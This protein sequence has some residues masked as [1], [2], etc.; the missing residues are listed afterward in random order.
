VPSGQLLIAVETASRE[1]SSD[2][3][4]YA[5]PPGRPQFNTAV[6]L[7]DKPEKG[8]YPRHLEGID[9][10]LVVREPSSC[11]ADPMQC[12]LPISAS[13]VSDE[14]A[15]LIAANYRAIASHL[16]ST[17][18]SSLTD[19]R[20]RATG[21][22]DL[23]KTLSWNHTCP[24]PVS[25]LVHEFIAQNAASSPNSPAVCASDAS[26]TYRELDE[27]A[28]A[29]A[30]FL[31][32]QGIGPVTIVPLCFGKSA[33]ATVAMLAVA[34]AGAAFT[35]LDQSFPIDALRSII[36]WVDAR[37]LFCSSSCRSVWDGIKV[38][39][40][41]T[42]LV[43]HEVSTELIAALSQTYSTGPPQI[44]CQPVQP[45]LCCLHFW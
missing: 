34:K 30:H 42:T 31:V 7:L 29:P 13:Q 6:C 19:L 32:C 28:S 5:R 15:S 14:A 43:V 44:F 25:G 12:T 39:D 41:G 11:S 35:L 21:L 40:D 45:P 24:P 37:F 38:D 1:S 36:R 3:F 27:A 26:L 8:I 20:K 10:V 9:L 22:E 18:D 17:P 23:Q 2:I 16:I 33:W 4:Q